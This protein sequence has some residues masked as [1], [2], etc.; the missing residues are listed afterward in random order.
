[1]AATFIEKETPSDQLDAELQQ[2]QE[3]KQVEAEVPDKYKGKSLADVVRMHQE[4]ESLIGRHS[5]ELGQLRQVTDSFI[6]RQLDSD[7]ATAKTT[8]PEKVDDTEFFTDPT[9]A[10]RKV[11]HEA[12]QPL[13]ETTQQTANQAGMARFLEKHPDAPTIGQTEGFQKWIMASKVRQQ[14]FAQS[15]KYDF[16]AAEELISTYKA[17]NPTKAED[18]ASKAPAKD[19]G[20]AKVELGKTHPKGMVPSQDDGDGKKIYRRADII[21]LMQTDPKRYQE[22]ESEIRQ[23][24][25]DK[26]V[27]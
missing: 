15:D 1:M 5:T 16:D 2:T 14:L 6:K 24:Y 20:K 11:V 17:L 13:R 4:A 23:A 12:L 26:R 21:R 9:T 10:V 18:P 19:A 27:R 3:Q 25:I 7:K 8:T 22:L